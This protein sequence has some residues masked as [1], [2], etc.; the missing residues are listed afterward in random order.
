MHVHVIARFAT[1][2]AWPGP[3]WGEGPV[4]PYKSVQLSDTVNA[5]K[6]ALK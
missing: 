1:D 5:L 4:L 6:I 2:A 3:V